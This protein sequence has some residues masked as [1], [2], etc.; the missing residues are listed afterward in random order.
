MRLIPEKTVEQWFALS[1]S[2]FFGPDIWLWADAAGWD[3]HAWVGATDTLSKW[4]LFELKAPEQDLTTLIDVRQL[5][6]YVDGFQ[7]GDHPDVVYVL[8]DPPWRAA[9][10]SGDQFNLR[11]APWNR[12]S[13]SSWSFCLPASDLLQLIRRGNP[14]P[15][16]PSTATIRCHT[17]VVTYPDRRSRV[18]APPLGLWLAWLMGCIE[19]PGT[20]WRSPLLVGPGFGQYEEWVLTSERL[21]RAG[22]SLAESEGDNEVSSRQLVAFGF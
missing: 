6:R 5:E 13:F 4:V 10:V 16:L 12:R 8:P 15:Q 9:P 18:F 22:R 21:Q 14:T 2:D 1:L 11:A 19:P 3:Q 7:I 20:A 17:G